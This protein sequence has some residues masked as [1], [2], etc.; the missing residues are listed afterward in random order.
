LG[1]NNNFVVVTK[2]MKQVPQASYILY[3]YNLLTNIK[4]LIYLRKRGAGVTSMCTRRSSIL[5]KFCEKKKKDAKDAIPWGT[6]YAKLSEDSNIQFIAW[7]NNI[8]VLFITSMEGGVQYGLVL[9][10]ETIKDFNLCKNN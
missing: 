1:E 6:L 7:K 8:L 10:Q 5:K 2:L 3:L 4:L 9:T